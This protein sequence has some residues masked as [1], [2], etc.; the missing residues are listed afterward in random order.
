M[1]RIST[2]KKAQR[3]AKLRAY[4]SMT[5]SLQTSLLVI[6]GLAGYMS[7]RCPLITWRTLLGLMG[8]LFLAISGSTILNMVYDRDLDA[9][10]GRTW[11]RPLPAGQVG[12]REGL[13][14]GFTLVGAGVGWAF[15]LLPQYGLLVLAGFFFDIVIYTLWLKRRTVWSILWG[16]IAGGMPV[17]AGRT[18]GL[19]RVDWVGLLLGAAVLLWIPTHILTFAIRY[20]RDY[21]RAKVPTFP[22]VYGEPLTR[23]LIV[24]SCVAAAAA[25]AG[26]AL[27]IGMNWGYLGLLGLLSAGLLILAVISL[28]RPS[29]QRNFGLFK[30]ASLYMLSSMLLLVVQGLG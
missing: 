10:M 14:L 26:A 24:F 22:A 28:R 4:W 27:G 23:K 29:F 18:L 9:R 20:K 7:A 12:V 17:L 1:T 6:T 13:V 19:G 25:M 30:Y 15:I 16:G 8:S 5:K 2:P 11:C 3:W 21:Q